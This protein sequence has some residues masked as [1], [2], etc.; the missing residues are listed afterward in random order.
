MTSKSARS[1]KARLTDWQLFTNNGN[2]NNPLPP[3]RRLNKRYPYFLDDVDTDSVRIRC[4]TARSRNQSA[5][6]TTTKRI[7]SA[8]SIY[9]QRTPRVKPIYLDLNEESDQIGV[10]SSR[11]LGTGRT[12]TACSQR[13]HIWEPQAWSFSYLHRAIIAIDEQAKK[14]YLAG[15]TMHA[16][17]AWQNAL[18]FCEQLTQRT[19]LWPENKAQL[20]EEIATLKRT[21]RKYMEEILRN[22]KNIHQNQILVPTRKCPMCR[23]EQ[24]LDQFHERFNND[25]RHVERTICDKCIYKNA[26]SRLENS[27]NIDMTCPEPNCTAKLNLKEIDQI[28]ETLN[29]I[30]SV[31]NSDDNSK[32]HTQE[33]KTEFIWCAHEQ[34]GSGQFHVLTENSSPMVT[35]LLCKRQTCARHHLKWHKGLT[36]QQYDQQQEQQAIENAQKQCPKCKYINEIDRNSHYKICSMCKYE[37]CSECKTDYKEIQEIGLHHHK[38]TCSHYKN[39]TK[40]TTTKSSAC[41]IL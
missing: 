38:P 41:T 20:D 10:Y 27:S 30:E 17:A 19:Q 6:S 1:K 39:N 40:K 36:C 4:R 26:K 28:N 23:I 22:N 12:P 9:Y 2:F 18:I 29:K 21:Y 31:E 14:D 13:S 32:S 33:R 11:K 5:I 35:C 37:Y 16:L 24:S 34:C 15:R 8:R 3:D 7:L 25:C